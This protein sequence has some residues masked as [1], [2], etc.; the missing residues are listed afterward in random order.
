[1]GQLGDA[2]QTG[3]STPGPVNALSGV[4]DVA[5]GY[6]F[7]LALKND[8]TVW[9][10]GYNFGGLLGLGNED[11]VFVPTQVPGLAGIVAI[12][13]AGLA[14]ARARG[15]RHP[16]RVRRQRRGTAGRWLDDRPPLA[17]D[18]SGNRGRGRDRRGRRPFARLKTDGTVWAWGQNYGRA[19]RRHQHARAR[20]PGP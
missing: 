13:A 7:S 11:N 3:R 20:A 2:T 9:S 18:G 19:G 4:R 10:W 6:Y 16:A 15:R 12:A 1:M 14:F 8:G 17:G 5:A